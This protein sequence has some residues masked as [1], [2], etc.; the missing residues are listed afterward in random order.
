MKNKNIII[1]VVFISLITVLVS[2]VITIKPLDIISI[3]QIQW[4]KQPTLSGTKYVGGTWRVTGLTDQSTIV[5]QEFQL[6]DTI[7]EQK[8]GYTSYPN[9]V[10][11]NAVIVKITQVE[12]PYYQLQFKKIGTYTVVESQIGTHKGVYGVEKDTRGKSNKVEVNIYQVD[13][14]SIELHIPFNIYAYKQ[15]LNGVEPL[16]TTY[17]SA[18]LMSDNSYNFDIPESVLSGYS[19]F[20]SFIEFFNPNTRNENLTINLMYSVGD[21]RY[22]YPSE[23]QNFYVVNAPLS[24]EVSTVNSFNAL[25]VDK[26]TTLISS[27]SPNQWAFHNYW[28]GDAEN[29]E[30]SIFKGTTVWGSSSVPAENH[31]G[32]FEN[33]GSATDIENNKASIR[34]GSLAGNWGMLCEG[35]FN[36]VPD[37]Y[38]L[39]EY[40]GW[41]VPY[42]TTEGTCVS[43]EWWQKRY[44]ITPSIMSNID[45]CRPT[46]L[47]LCNYLSALSLTTSDGL[48]PITK[49]K[50][51]Y[52]AVINRV[53]N[54]DYWS[55]GYSADLIDNYYKL[56]IPL[57]G[58]KWFYTLD[59]S[60]DVI[61]AVYAVQTQYPNVNIVSGG[62]TTISSLPASSSVTINARIKADSEGLCGYGIQILTQD[63]AQSIKISGADYVYLTAN[64]EKDVSVTITNQGMLTQ[65]TVAKFKF[66]SGNQRQITDSKEFQFTLVSGDNAENT[67]LDLYVREVEKP[68]SKLGGIS[69]RIN[70]GITK[71]LHIDRITDVNGYVQFDLEQWSGNI[72]IVA[73]DVT[74]VYERKFESINVN[75][76]PNT[77]T[78]YL[79]K[80]PYTPEDLMKYLPYI[81]AGIAVAI[82]VFVVIFVMQRK[83][84]SGVKY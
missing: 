67:V 78:V 18:I 27:D 47:S 68:T 39:F 80:A 20:S 41:Y 62:T 71:E 63:I 52:F 16:I 3:T 14:S 17:N 35:R 81:I 34:F 76:G 32:Y 2:I 15:T 57:L 4:V 23:L 51:E 72:E 59:M 10:A 66:I 13:Y 31:G 46:G 6:N 43:D 70:Y 74:E 42:N 44:P 61:G 82:S 49:Q 12:K 65:N 38:N 9:M 19:G 69:V 37:P 30:N 53:S 77:K 33:W 28:F 1:F 79:S 56:S 7:L 45:N 25:G 36:G 75:S 26:L 11:Q 22:Y 24:R 40:P 83:P 21:T 48:T 64:Q 54:L 29:K 84:K 50:K 73:T 8:G 60:T 58:R 55:Y 5:L